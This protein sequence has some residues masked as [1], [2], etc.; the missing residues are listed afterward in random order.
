MRGRTTIMALALLK[1]LLESIVSANTSAAAGGGLT[2]VRYALLPTNESLFSRKSACQISVLRADA[3]S[4][5][6]Q[7]QQYRAVRER[8]QI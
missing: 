4:Y 3:W 7:V 8:C 2:V 1:P 5:E 6:E